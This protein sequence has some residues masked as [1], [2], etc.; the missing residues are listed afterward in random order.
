MIGAVQ[1][2]GRVWLGNHTVSRAELPTQIREAVSHGAERKVYN[3]ADARARYGSVLEVLSAVRSAGIENV[4]F[5]VGE[6]G[7]PSKRTREFGGSWSGRC[8]W[9][10]SDTVV[11]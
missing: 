4:G 5:L 8:K 1:P 3:H 11:W 10:E 7:T 9:Q 6:R 2:D